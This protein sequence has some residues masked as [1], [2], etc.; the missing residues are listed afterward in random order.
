MEERV[1]TWREML[2]EMRVQAQLQE[3]QRNAL[4]KERAESIK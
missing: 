2:A 4:V 3:K 1:D